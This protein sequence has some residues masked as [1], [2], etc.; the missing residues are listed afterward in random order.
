SDAEAIA[1]RPTA[2]R[3]DRLSRVP[4]ARPLRL[5]GLRIGRAQL[6]VQACAGGSPTG[7]TAMLAD[8]IGAFQDMVHAPDAEY[9]DKPGDLRDSSRTRRAEPRASPPRDD[10]GRAIRA[11]EG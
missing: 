2:F 1:T 5:D 7:C 6:Q 3:K 8:P 11:I 4:R 9:R 10:Q